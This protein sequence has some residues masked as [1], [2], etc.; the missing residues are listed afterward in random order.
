MID[1]HTMLAFFSTAII[2]ALSP[3]PDN[4]FVMAQ[5]V[6]NGRKAGVFVTFG[7]ATG[8]VGHTVA[9]ALGLAALVNSSAFAF[10][11]LKYI[12]AAYLIYLAWQAFRAG[13]S[14]AEKRDVPHF[15]KGELYRRGIVM[16]LTNPKVSLFFMA[17]LPQFV[18]PAGGSVTMQFFLLGG[19]FILA[20]ILVF[21]AISMLAG[22][23]G[24]RYRNS[25]GAQSVVNR[26]AAALFVG[27]A[28]KLVLTER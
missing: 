12:G 8:L 5:A 20:T 23:V 22:G 3:G 24:E 15:S 11:L 16:N 28:L 19:L 27:L 13:G 21:G 14:T 25:P 6:Q 1:T 7:L 17:F 9:V 2:L 4:L 18:D 10:T 26:V